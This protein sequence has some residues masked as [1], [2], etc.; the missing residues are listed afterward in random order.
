MVM[1]T[2]APTGNLR[3]KARYA[4]ASLKVF[5]PL[6]LASSVDDGAAVALGVTGDACVE[7]EGASSTAAAAAPRLVVESRVDRVERRARR[8]VAGVMSAFASA[9]VRAALS[10][11]AAAVRDAGSGFATGIRDTG[12]DFVAAGVFAAASGLAAAARDSDPTSAS[13][14]LAVRTARRLVAPRTGARGTNTH[15]TWGIGFP[16]KRRPSSKSHG[17]APWNSWNESFESTTASARRATSRMNASPRPIAPAGGVIMPP[18]EMASSYQRFSLGL[19]RCPK[20]ASTMTVTTLNG[21][22]L[23]NASRASSSCAMLGRLRPSVAMLDPSTTRCDL[24]FSSRRGAIGRL[25]GAL[26]GGGI[27]GTNLV[28]DAFG[29]SA[30][31]ASVVD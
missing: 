9:R 20:V 3:A 12:S 11:F 17:C 19:M 22:S 8:S 29:A 14:S 15:P 21:C 2:G 7:E 1:S 13:R 31:C 24:C 28:E 10:V 18:L 30:G 26:T 6:L 25:A 27:L 23:T 4:A 5:E 16:P